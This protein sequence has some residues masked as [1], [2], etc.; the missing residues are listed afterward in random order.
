MRLTPRQKEIL[1]LYSR[2]A[3]R[4]VICRDLCIAGGTLE[5][6]VARI[7]ERL[8]TTGITHSVVVAL[9][10]GEIVLDLEGECADVPDEPV[11]VAA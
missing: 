7:K 9:A 4:T 11:L 5:R 2:G 6:H 8:G 1:I 10:R 3:T